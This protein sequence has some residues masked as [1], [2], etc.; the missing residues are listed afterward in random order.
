MERQ[1]LDSRLGNRLVKTGLTA[2]KKP[3]HLINGMDALW[4]DKNRKKS[5]SWTGHARYREQ[6]G[7]PRNRGPVASNGCR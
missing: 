6:V 7:M 1:E 5:I 4:V 2:L 3:R